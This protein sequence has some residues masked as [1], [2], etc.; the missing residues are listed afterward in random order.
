MSS[1]NLPPLQQPL[2]LSLLMTQS[3]QQELKTV[4]DC[5]RLAFQ[6]Q[7]T[8]KFSGMAKKAAEID[9]TSA[10]GQV[11]DCAHWDR[12][13]HDPHS[14]S[15]LAERIS[16]VN[17]TNDQCRRHKE[18]STAQMCA[19]V[20]ARHSNKKLWQLADIVFN[21][22]QIGIEVRQFLWPQRAQQ[23]FLDQFGSCNLQS[24][25]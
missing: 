3:P 25:L 17:A 13:D 9:L 7:S 2:L 20:S 11:E 8:A 22:T 16:K 5:L 14:D 12:M 1:P 21:P 23:N 10:C 6:L 18:Q 4:D 19:F 24:S 15:E